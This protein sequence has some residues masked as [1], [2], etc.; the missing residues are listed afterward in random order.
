VDEKYLPNEN[1]EILKVQKQVL[2]QI[3]QT[4]FSLL[5]LIIVNNVKEKPLK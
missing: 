4:M 3:Q 1:H 2:K 5:N